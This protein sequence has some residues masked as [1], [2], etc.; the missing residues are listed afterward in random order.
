MKGVPAMGRFAPRELRP[1]DSCCGALC[2]AKLACHVQKQTA[3]GADAPSP[4]LIRMIGTREASVNK[5]IRPLAR[6][7]GTH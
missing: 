1:A 3:G 6:M 2:I 4:E 7:S 5:A